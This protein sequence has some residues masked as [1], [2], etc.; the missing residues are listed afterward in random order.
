MERKEVIRS[1]ERYTQ[2]GCISRKQ[3][4][5]WLGFK[6]IHSVDEILKGLARIGK[7][8]FFIP[9][10]AERIVEVQRYED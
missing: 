4:A 10:V 7:G 2:A 5:D 3:L 9:E 8:R 1:L 6:D